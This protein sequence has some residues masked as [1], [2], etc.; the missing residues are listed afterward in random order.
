MDGS[1]GA[2]VGCEA[3]A[4]IDQTAQTIAGTVRCCVS[5][6]LLRAL[7]RNYG[8]T[9][10]RAMVHAIARQPE[11]I[12]KEAVQMD[13]VEKKHLIPPPILATKGRAENCPSQGQAGF[14]FSGKPGRLGV[15]SPDWPGQAHRR[16]QEGQR[17]PRYASRRRGLF[18]EE[19]MVG[20]DPVRT[21]TATAIT[22]CVVLEIVKERLLRVLH[23]EHAFSD[24]FMQFT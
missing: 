24:F 11:R 6:R 16:F 2:L 19:S 10:A 15:L 17:K 9:P 1:G 5:V 22:V 8:P 7:E 12:Q 18:G 20:T 21:T 4:S 14:L 23:E 3:N 13:G